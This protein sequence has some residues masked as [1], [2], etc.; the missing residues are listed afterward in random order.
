A[1]NRSRG[2]ARA[3]KIGLG[4]RTLEAA[5]ESGGGGPAEPERDKHRGQSVKSLVA[6]GGKRHKA[7][8]ARFADLDVAGCRCDD[9]AV[10]DQEGF[11]SIGPDRN[12]AWDGD[13]RPVENSAGDF[14]AVRALRIK[15]V[16]GAKVEQAG[17]EAPFLVGE[18]AAPGGEL[19]IVQAEL[20]DRG[21]P[22]IDQ[23]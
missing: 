2:Y 17:F 20:V 16:T 22:R 10:V 4:F 19:E 6:A 21:G 23:S 11:G 5:A 9:L 7:F 14:D 1:L 12:L 8:K 13:H 3:V 15:P 18:G